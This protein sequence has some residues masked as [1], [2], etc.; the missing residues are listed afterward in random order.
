MLKLVLHLRRPWNMQELLVS[1]F[2]VVVG[3]RFGKNYLSVRLT[4]AF[5][6]GGVPI[7]SIVVVPVQRTASEIFAKVLPQLEQS[8]FLVVGHCKRH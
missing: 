6:E 5:D 7:L 2:Q 1:L 4:K 8:Y 3:L